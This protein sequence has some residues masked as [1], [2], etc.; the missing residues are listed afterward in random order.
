MS[1]YTVLCAYYYGKH[2]NATFKQNIIHADFNKI[3]VG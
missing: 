3:I 2:L 1:I